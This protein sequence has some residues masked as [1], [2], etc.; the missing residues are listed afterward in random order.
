MTPLPKKP[1]H[2]PANPIP[3]LRGGPAGN[4]PGE[5]GGATPSVSPATKST[6]HGKAGAERVETPAPLTQQGFA[7][8]DSLGDEVGRPQS[9]TLQSETGARASYSRADTLGTAGTQAPPVDTK[10]N[11]TAYQRD[12][13]RKRRAEQKAGK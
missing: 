4:D 9:A 10:F 6:D 1:E 12:Y 2:E 5:A 8:P 7:T 11:K 13:M 3:L